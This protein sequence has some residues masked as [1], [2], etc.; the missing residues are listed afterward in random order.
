MDKA[1]KINTRA[2][3][4]IL[5]FFLLIILF[6][7][8]VGIQ[9]LDEIIDPEILIAGYLNPELPIPF[10]VQLI[11]VIKAVHVIGGFLFVGLGIVHIVKNWKALK[12]YLKK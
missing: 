3:V 4:S 6:V 10:S 7:T 9:I 1:R 2:I 11:H 12:S 8:A 5:L